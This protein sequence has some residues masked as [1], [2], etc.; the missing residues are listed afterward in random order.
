MEGRPFDC[1]FLTDYSLHCICFYTYRRTSLSD[2]PSALPWRVSTQQSFTYGQA[3]LD[4]TQGV[5]PT[6]RASVG[7]R[8]QV[9]L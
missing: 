7:A 1:S 8:R 9:K 5:V 2:A 3:E 6:R 4:P